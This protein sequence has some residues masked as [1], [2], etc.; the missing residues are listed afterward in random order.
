M[1]VGYIS[2]LSALVG[3]LIGGLTTGTMTWM[4]LHAQARALRV[5]AE[6]VRHQDLFR[7][8]IVASSKAYGNALVSN[9]P[10]VQDLVE[11]YSL[12]SRMRILCSPEVV[13]CADKALREIIETF[14]AP[15]KTVRELSE[16]MESGITVDPLKEFSEVAR[17]ELRAFAL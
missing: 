10:Q 8:F 13:A 7:D 17:E 11:L 12:V 2:A 6:S 15:N 9:E 3:S 4:S 14:F 1:D 5:T 16:L